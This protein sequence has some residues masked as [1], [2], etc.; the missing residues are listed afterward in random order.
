[1]SLHGTVSGHM[2]FAAAIPASIIMAFS[3]AIVVFTDCHTVEKEAG[4][5][6]S[7]DAAGAGAG[8]DVGWGDD[9]TGPDSGSSSY[10]QPSSSSSSL[11][12]A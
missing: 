12:Y 6:L 8:V 4:S 1:M 9:D 10:H 2:K 5:C 7:E 11:K 3:F